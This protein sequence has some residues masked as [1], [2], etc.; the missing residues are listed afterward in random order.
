MTIVNQNRNFLHYYSRVIVKLTKRQKLSIQTQVSV[1]F[2]LPL[3]GAW[4]TWFTAVTAM[5]D[6]ALLPK[7]KGTLTHCGRAGGEKSRS[8][9]STT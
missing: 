7:A 2:T 8:V 4:Y 5:S 3:Q 9:E 1:A 6:T